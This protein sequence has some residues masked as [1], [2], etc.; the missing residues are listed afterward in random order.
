MI[1]YTL[2]CDKDHHF[3]E[4]FTSSSRFDEMAEKGEIACPECHSHHVEKA[5]MA[6]SLS[7]TRNAV[8]GSCMDMADAPPCAQTC[9]GG[10]FAR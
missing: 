8:P 7:G 9:G 5:P 10:C 4:W 6:P 2:K 1:V 3:E